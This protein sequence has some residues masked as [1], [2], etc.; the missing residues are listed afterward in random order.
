MPLKQALS[1]SEQWMENLSRHLMTASPAVKCFLGS[2][3]NRKSRDVVLLAKVFF[4]LP[5]V[6]HFVTPVQPRE[7]A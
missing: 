6:E 1:L 3:T 2:G 4:I 5:V 7:S